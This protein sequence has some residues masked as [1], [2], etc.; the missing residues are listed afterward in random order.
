[1]YPER[2]VM[3]WQLPPIVSANPIFGARAEVIWSTFKLGAS[4]L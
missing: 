3:A 4:Q 1:M 2:R